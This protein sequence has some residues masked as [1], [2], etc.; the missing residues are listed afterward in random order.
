[1]AKIL[2][3]WK[4]WRWTSSSTS[5]LKEL[6]SELTNEQKLR[7]VESILSQST[8][9][10]FCAHLSKI[11]PGPWTFK[12][13]FTSLQGLSNN[14]VKK[15]DYICISTC[16]ALP[17]IPCK[18]LFFWRM[19]SYHDMTDQNQIVINLIKILANFDRW[20][21]LMANIPNINKPHLPMSVLLK[22]CIPNIESI[23]SDIQ[24]PGYLFSSST[25]FWVFLKSSGGTI[26]FYSFGNF[27]KHLGKDL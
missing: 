1:M 26:F 9:L 15:C 10:S 8:K 16:F 21:Q 2:K 6:L 17:G 18:D 12:P 5:S 25:G 14:P 4:C 27:L 19:F 3:I 24:N 11:P 20:C 7:Q 13:L 22:L 23:T